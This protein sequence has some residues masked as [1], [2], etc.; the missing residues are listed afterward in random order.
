MNS[1]C[2]C[3]DYPGSKVH[4]TNLG[5]IW[6]REDP[7]GPQVGP[8]NFAIKVAYP[9]LESETAILQTTVSNA[10]SQMKIVKLRLKFHWNLSLRVSSLLSHD[11]V[12]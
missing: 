3:C 8:M 12:R 1:V 9:F 6:G 10:F 4:G 7:D 11:Y 5:P 2:N